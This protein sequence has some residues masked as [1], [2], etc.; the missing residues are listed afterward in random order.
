MR[1][2]RGAEDCADAAGANTGQVAATNAAAGNTRRN[3][4]ANGVTA[5]MTESFSLFERPARA[6]R[7]QPLIARGS[8]LFCR[9][10]RKSMRLCTTV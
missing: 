6:R 4:A 10:R 3:N 2:T 7:G 5:R 9:T 8:A 1:S